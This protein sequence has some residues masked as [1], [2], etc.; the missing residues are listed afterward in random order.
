[1]ANIQVHVIFEG[2]VQGIGFRFTVER[3]ASNL[4]IKGWVKNLPSGE[5]EIVCQSDKKT[6]DD[7]LGKIR[8]QFSNYIRGEEIDLIDATDK[9]DNFQIRF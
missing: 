7:F 8:T 5:V 9:F 6:I 3:L 2:H 1:M 4:G